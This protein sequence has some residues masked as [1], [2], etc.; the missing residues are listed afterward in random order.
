MSE[1]ENI[2]KIICKIMD[3]QTLGKGSNKKNAKKES[4][5]K[6]C[7]LLQLW[8]IIIIINYIMTVNKINVIQKI[9]FFY[10]GQ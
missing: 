9:L 5:K 4:A 7:E 1:N 6:M 2:F 10:K 8:N 3:N